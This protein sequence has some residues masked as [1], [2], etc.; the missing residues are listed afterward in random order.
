MHPHEIERMLPSLT[1][2]L[3]GMVTILLVL[4]KWLLE[5]VVS[6]TGA[7]VI[8]IT[9][10]IFRHNSAW[11]VYSQSFLYSSSRQGVRILL[12]TG[13]KQNNNDD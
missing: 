5:M 8:V 1:P 2:V 11:D 13:R 9:T 4:L 3:L 7:I 12:A 6:E 10:D